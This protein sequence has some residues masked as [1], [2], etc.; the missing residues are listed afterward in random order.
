MNTTTFVILFA[1]LVPRQSCIDAWKERNDPKK[2]EAE[3]QRC[4]KEIEG[5]RDK[6]GASILY[7]TKERI[8]YDPEPVQQFRMNGDSLF[9]APEPTKDER[10]C[11]DIYRGSF[12]IV[13]V[14]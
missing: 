14:K 12:S 9:T 10:D 13:G 1:V 4:L 6:N 3:Y 5:S 8:G 11:Y 7:C 2:Q